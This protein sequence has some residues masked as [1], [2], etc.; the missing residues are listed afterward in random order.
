MAHLKA[1][2][3]AG[4]VIVV[5]IALFAAVVV[6]ISGAIFWEGL[7]KYRVRFSDATGLE[8]REPV[9]LNGMIVGRVLSVGIA[10]DDVTKVDAV[11]GVNHGT[12]VFDTATAKVTYMSI[13]GDYYLAISQPRP[14]RSLAPGGYIK[15][16]R[17]AD[18]SQII[19]NIGSLSRSVEGLLES[20]R[21]VFAEDN[22]AALAGT[23]RSVEPLIS[24]LRLLTSRLR[25]TVDNLNGVIVE[26]RRP[27]TRAMSALQSDLER[28]DSAL[29]GFDRLAKGLGRWE[30]VG[31][32]YLDDILQNLVGASENLRALSGELKREPWRLLYRPEPGQR[33]KE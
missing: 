32:L 17:S 6:V 7:T 13:I 20:V 8:P 33:E 24:D 23:L 27:I 5:A 29:T 1:E 16:E 14:G 25:L 3:K 31:G 22:V 15:S 4:A 12:P 21:P 18:I 10:P 28:I 30:R 19:A 26:N 11:I 2:L 9:R